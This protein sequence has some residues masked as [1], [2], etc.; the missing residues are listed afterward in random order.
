[1][2]R[3]FQCTGVILDYTFIIKLKLKF[4]ARFSHLCHKC[5]LTLKKASIRIYYFPILVSPKKKYWLGSNLKTILSFHF[6]LF[7]KTTC[8]SQLN[9]MFWFEDTL[10]FLQISA[11]ILLNDL[12]GCSKRRTCCVLTY[13]H[14]SEAWIQEQITQQTHSDH[15]TSH[16]IFTL[17]VWPIKAPRLLMNQALLRGLQWSP[18]HTQ[19]PAE[20]K[21][22]KQ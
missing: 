16:A 15:I 17:W 20:V 5:L 11:V 14:R 22:I 3:T 1:M 10:K 2:F 8:N 18:A 9:W 7:Y 12:L 13:R 21:Q 6:C 4:A 19:R